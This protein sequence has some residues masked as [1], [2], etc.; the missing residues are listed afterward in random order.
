MRGP[1]VTTGRGRAAGAR[2]ARAWLSATEW[3][4]VSAIAGGD[5]KVAPWL[6]TLVLDAIEVESLDREQAVGAELLKETN[7]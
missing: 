7:E 3:A 6:R 5:K 2:E 1:A 4:A